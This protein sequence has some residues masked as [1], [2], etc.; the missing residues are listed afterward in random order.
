MKFVSISDTHNKHNK[1]VVPD[2]DIVFHAGD[3]TGMGTTREITEFCEWFGSL[4]HPFKVLIAGNHD[5]GFQEDFKKHKQICEANDII[6]LQD[7]GCEIN[8]IKVY[9]SPQTPEFCSWAFNCWRTEAEVKL[10]DL[11]G[12]DYDFI[13]THW[14]K[15]PED[16]DILLTH[17]P[18]HGILDLCANGNVGCEILKEKVE[19]IKPQFHI[20]GHIHSDKGEKITEDTVFINASCLNDN[21][22]PNNQ[23]IKIWTI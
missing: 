2:A 6:Y 12:F 10:N 19:E 9:G 3:A 17:G 21:Y 7:S 15:I 20:F 4:P 1:I 11:H 22:Y 5:W 16:T 14:K 8:G 23:E 18:A 13:G